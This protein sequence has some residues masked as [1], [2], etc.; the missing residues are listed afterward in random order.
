MTTRER[1][2]T[3]LKREKPDRLPATTH[4]LIPYFLKDFE[5]GISETDFFKQFKLDQTCWIHHLT[6]AS[7]KDRKMEISDELYQPVFES[8]SW[9]ISAELLRTHPYR[10]VRYTVTTPKGTLSTVLE[11]NAYT[12]WVRE[13]L[14]KDK[15]DIDIIAEYAPVP[16]CDIT[17]VRQ[18]AKTV[19]NKGLI[20]GVIPGFDFYGQPGCW[21]DAACL[22]SVSDLILATFDDPEWVH[23]LLSV[24][25]TRKMLYIKSLSGAPFDIIELGGGDA[26]TTV[27]SPKIF[28]EFVGPYDQSLI[29]A[30]HEVGQRIVYHTCG[31]MMP[32]LENIASMGT[33]AMETFT[34]HS[35]GGDTDLAE[36]K[37]RIGDKV[38]MIGGL[39][40]NRFFTAARPK[41][42]EEEVFRCFHEAG[43][44]GGFII[45]P[46]DHFFAA[47]AELIQAF[48]RAVHQCTY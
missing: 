30:A 1:L 32:I 46:S 33:D 31:G 42:V 14:I 38:C 11:T 29:A 35:M 34:P 47:N 44:G 27:I 18:D 45:A 48:S 25:E 12:S 9:L 43:E 8:D 3:A 21:Q 26:S 10:C 20:R 22:Y 16:I 24:M 37:R 36:A 7:K 23:T 41:E 13:H 19:G 40:Q 5:G 2:L 28:N 17:Q 6:A 4:E 39:D 15:H